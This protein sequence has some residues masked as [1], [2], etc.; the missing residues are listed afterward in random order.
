MNKFYEVK[1]YNMFKLFFQNNQEYRARLDNFL[2]TL[3]CEVDT[4]DYQWSFACL[5]NNGLSIIPKLNLIKDIG[6]GEEATHT[7]GKNRGFSRIEN[8]KLELRGKHRM[9]VVGILNMKI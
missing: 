1:K 6:F 8:Y 9:Y 2:R 4:W 5:I 7:K 3:A